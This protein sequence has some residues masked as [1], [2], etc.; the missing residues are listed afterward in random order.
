[1][2]QILSLVLAGFIGGLVT[3]GGFWLLREDNHN[4]DLGYNPYAKSVN[5]VN[6]SPESTVEAPFDFSVA[7]ARAMPAV[8][9]ISA[10]GKST[11]AGNK[12]SGTTDPWSFFFGDEMPQ[13]HPFFNFDQPMQGTGSGVIYSPD[14]YIITN[15]HVVEYAEEVEVTTVDNKKYPAKIIG[16]YADGDLAVLKIEAENLPVL[17]LA[18][19]DQVKIGEW[20][21]AVGNPLELNS[22]VT[23]G[24]VS[25]KGRDLNIIKGRS[26]IESF[27][28]TDA[29][30]NPGNSGGALVDASGRLIGI[31][32]A[33]A[34]Q[35]GFFEGYSFAI[36]V[37]LARRIVDDIIENGSYRRGFLGINIQDLNQELADDLGLDITQGIYV[38]SLEDGGAAQMAGVLPDDV[39]VGVNGK[40]VRSSADLLETIGGSKAGE[41]VTL[42]L[43]RRS[44]TI[45]IPVRLKAAN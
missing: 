18:D 33:I 14:G 13:G 36:P 30:V 10:K 15:N 8:V 4:G 37:N 45:D 17:R 42:S 2:K 11:S 24:I 21:L 41:T 20:V 40:A 5:L 25:A 23:A 32:T 12:K 44:K 26:S 28:Q 22:T 3:V 39:I 29:A 35:T 16:T 9:H 27:I 6:T 19:S 7:A 38:E 43:K 31:N 34:T 1:M